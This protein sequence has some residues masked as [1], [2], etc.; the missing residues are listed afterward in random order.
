ME[1][2]R[3]ES[4]Y[5][6]PIGVVVIPTGFTP[7]GRARFVAL[8]S[9]SCG[10][11]LF[12]DT[13]TPIPLLIYKSVAITDN[14]GS[15]TTS[16]Y[17][18]GYLPSDYHTGKESF[19][20]SESKYCSSS[21]LIPSP[22]LGDKLNPEY[23]K[24]LKNGNAMSDLN[25]FY[26]TKTM[27]EIGEQYTAAKVAWDYKDGVSNTQWCLPSIGELGIMYA[28]MKKINDVISKIGGYRVSASTS[29][30]EKH[31][32]SSTLWNTDD[33]ISP[34]KLQACAG[35]NYGSYVQANLLGNIY[36]YVYPFGLL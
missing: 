1:F 25:G 30:H 5:G 11:K 36:H 33:G 24:Y 21:D 12:G 31:I 6:T 15:T 23:V 7:D 2:E 29:G 35:S 8:D 17:H 32:F 16:S 10:M 19:V 4:K 28:R 14:L 13:K 22:Y 9:N 27:V 18:V 20:D 34:F 26:N 3:W